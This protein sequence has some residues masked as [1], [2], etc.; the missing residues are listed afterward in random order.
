[1]TLKLYLIFI[2]SMSAITFCLYI[3]DKQCAKNNLR[4][5]PEVALLIMSTVGG[6]IGGLIAMYTVHHKTKH[7]YF[8]AINTVMSIVIVFIG[9]MIGTHLPSGL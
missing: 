4:R 6:S 5:I 9:V 2:V 8:V 1:M 7:W 3:L